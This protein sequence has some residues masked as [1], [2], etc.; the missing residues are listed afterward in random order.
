MWLLLVSLECGASLTV[1]ARFPRANPLIIAKFLLPPI[2]D[3][4]HLISLR[5]SNI[6]RAQT[7]TDFLVLNSEG[8]PCRFIQS[9]LSVF[10]GIG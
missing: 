9:E 5:R 6:Q 2:A 1:L 10:I 3:P 7:R 4:A 8:V